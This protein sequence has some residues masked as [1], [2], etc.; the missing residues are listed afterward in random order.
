[1][2]LNTQLQHQAMSST[3]VAHG[4]LMHGGLMHGGLMHGGL[5]HGHLY[6]LDWWTG[7]VDWTR[8][9]WSHK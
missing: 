1:M 5:M 4:G 6:S 9:D 8:L 3:N 2:R 7:L